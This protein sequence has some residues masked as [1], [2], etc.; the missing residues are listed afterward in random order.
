MNAVKSREILDY[1]L[2]F[3]LLSIPIVPIMNAEF[4]LLQK[5]YASIDASFLGIFGINAEILEYS[6]G[7]KTIP[8]VYYDGKTVLIDSAC[9]GI[10]SFYFL[11]ALLFASKKELKKKLKYLALGAVLLFIVN[12][13][14]I[15]ASSALFF[16]DLSTFDNIVWPMS[17]NLTALIIFYYFIR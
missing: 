13:V 12:T 16:N 8:S 4:Y 2:M 6:S 14:R 10:R 5:A 17:L 3:V 15:V 1:L 7:A 9:T 11:F